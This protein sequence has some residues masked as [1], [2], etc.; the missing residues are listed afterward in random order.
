MTEI[1]QEEL[2][3]FKNDSLISDL[4]KNIENKK[5][6]NESKFN[7]FKILKLD[8]FEIR[9]SN[10]LA[11]LLNPKENH[12][13]NS[14]FLE[15]FLNSTLK[16]YPAINYNE[17]KIET[18]Y[19]TN[20]NRRIDILI[21]SSN[22]VCIIENKYGS[23]E[24]DEQCKHYKNFIENYSDFKEYKNKYYIFLDIEK[25]NEEKFKKELYGY[26]AIIY[27]DI[28]LILNNLLKEFPIEP[29]KKEI[30]E[31][32][33]QIIKEK[34]IFMDE[35]IKNSCREIY[36]KYQNTIET[37]EEYK[38][39]LQN[40][41]YEIFK[42]I[43]QSDNFINADIKDEEM[44]YNNSTGCGIRF[45]PKEYKDRN[46]IVKP[47]KLTKYSK[48]FALEFK[49]KLKF[50]IYSIE[51]NGNKEKWNTIENI[52]INACSMSKEEIEEKIS[53]LINSRKL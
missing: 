39:I 12:G 29:I 53:E 35:N 47:N 23:D 26:K 27:R 24:H 5:L 30:I 11:W 41:I 43:L 2:D 32:Y 37:L 52:E 13:F 7:I 40:D 51:N 18:E 36:A 8:N 14:A 44:G 28:L 31:E 46:D 21:R 9:H 16:S 34:Y 15:A 25:P 1:K 42:K 10:F 48:F 22:F 4:E 50:S 20:E 49:D 17:V 6:E 3:C 45:I 38:R 33:I 19:C